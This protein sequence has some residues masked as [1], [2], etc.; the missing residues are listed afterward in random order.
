[1]RPC[2]FKCVPQRFFRYFIRGVYILVS[3]KVNF[4][5]VETTAMH[6]C[7]IPGKIYSVVPRPSLASVFTSLAVYIYMEA[8]KK[9]MVGRPGN[10]ARPF[11][12]FT[13]SCFQSL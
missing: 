13:S 1:M 6:P 2:C 11:P 4:F 10:K 12:Q 8:T 3:V 5:H 9:W 7:I